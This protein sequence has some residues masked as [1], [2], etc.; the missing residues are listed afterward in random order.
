[1]RNTALFLTA[2]LASCAL[3]TVLQSLQ[4]RGIR[5]AQRH[6]CVGYHDTFVRRDGKWLFLQRVAG[7]GAPAQTSR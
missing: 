3:L 5:D 7:G 1:M 4:A 6:G 2:V